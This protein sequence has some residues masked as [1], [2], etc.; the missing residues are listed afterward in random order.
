VK[1][2]GR[3]EEQEWLVHTLRGELKLTGFPGAVGTFLLADHLQR[4][5]P[6]AGPPVRVRYG[7]VPSGR[8]WFPFDPEQPVSITLPARARP[9]QIEPVLLH[10]LWHFLLFRHCGAWFARRDGGAGRLAWERLCRLEDARDE[11]AVRHAVLAWRLPLD[12]IVHYWDR[13][14]ELLG[15]SGCSREQV[16]ERYRLSFG[17]G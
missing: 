5:R 11:R 12:L 7:G 6:P 13:E 15:E 16:R 8:T 10:E 3:P 4:P 17:E 9:E 14:E 1:L 2:E